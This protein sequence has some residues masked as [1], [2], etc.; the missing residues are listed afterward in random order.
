MVE[1]VVGAVVGGA[2]VWAHLRGGSAPAAAAG[3]QDSLARVDRKLEA[4]ERDRMRSQGALTESL[5]AMGEANEKLRKEA[6]G[7]R[8]A[9]RSPNVR[10]RWGELQLQRVCELAGMVE[11]CDFTQQPTLFDGDA[12]LRPDVVVHLPGGRD[13]VIDAKAPLEAYLSA[14]DADD[15]R[16]RAERLAAFGDHVRGHVARL[17]AKSYWSQFDAAPEFVV[18]FLPSEAVFGAALEQC[19]ELIEEGVGRSVLIAT[20]T[21]LIALLRAVAFGWRQERMAQSAVE[22]AA[23]GRELYERLAVLTEHVARVGRHLDGSVKA[24]NEAVGSLESRVLVTA[25]RFVEH[26]AAPAA[27]TLE[28]PPHVERTARVPV[29]GS[30]G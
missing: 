4:L 18:L 8:S 2:L 30:V 14:H 28:E 17:S 11:H 1:F 6:S 16:V 20:P 22:V 23:T 26:G 7:L 21:T 27:R 3:L 25:R 10:G 5:R 13:V 19:P 12:R 29:G 9:L 24:Y 15:E